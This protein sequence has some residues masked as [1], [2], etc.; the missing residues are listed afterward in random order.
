MLAIRVQMCEFSS[1]TI[2]RQVLSQDV[3]TASDQSVKV[4][5]SLGTGSRVSTSIRHVVMPHR[6]AAEGLSSPHYRSLL[7]TYAHTVEGRGSAGPTLSRTA[8]SHNAK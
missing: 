3:L 8:S 6:I 7:M 1:Q 2:S 5:E 4:L